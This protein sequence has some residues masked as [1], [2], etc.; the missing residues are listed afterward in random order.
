MVSRDGVRS[1]LE[2]VSAALVVEEGE[3]TIEGRACMLRRL[4]GY[5][6][7]LRCSTYRSVLQESRDSEVTHLKHAMVIG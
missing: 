5:P 3:R 1:A 2:M 6:D 7:H 4:P